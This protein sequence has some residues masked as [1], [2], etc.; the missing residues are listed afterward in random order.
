MKECS[1][2]KNL[3]Q[4]ATHELETRVG[5]R[6]WHLHV[7]R[8]TGSSGFMVA[9][10]GAERAVQMGW[11]LAADQPA[12]RRVVITLPHDPAPLISFAPEQP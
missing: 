10:E 8:E 5:S 11:A 9:V 3:L 2:R 1:M 7:E 4:Q 12:V 6:W